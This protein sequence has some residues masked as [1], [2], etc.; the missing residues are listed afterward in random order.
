MY[1]S[2]FPLSGSISCQDNVSDPHA[3]IGSS[4]R[5]THSHHVANILLFYTS[6]I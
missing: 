5:V 6:P 3:T 1:L 4:T 2:K